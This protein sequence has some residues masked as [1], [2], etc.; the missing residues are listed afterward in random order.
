MD[1]VQLFVTCLI[2]TLQPQIGEAVLRVLKRSGVDVAFP[3]DQTC[4]GQPSY[5]AGLR[6]EARK[7]AKHT[8]KVFEEAPGPVVIP[9]G[10]CTAMIR[11]GYP[12]LF[13][14]DPL[15]L[16]RAKALSRRTFELTEF[17]VDIL[18]KQDLGVR[19]PGKITYHPSCHLL[20][21][22]GI[23]HQPRIL[24]KHIRGSDL[25]ELPNKEECCGFGGIFSIKHPEISDEM[26]KRKINNIQTTQAETVV[27]C[28]TGCLMHING[29]LHRMESHQKVMHIAEILAHDKD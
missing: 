13:V 3:Q 28:D 5:N 11:Y 18:G 12:E 9:S 24:L 27:V 8:I 16:T 1:T 6:S 22:L 29:A 23:D 7:T 17:L 2:D 10:S 15:W 14:D 21:G 25:V 20:R 4:C 19:Y 26:L